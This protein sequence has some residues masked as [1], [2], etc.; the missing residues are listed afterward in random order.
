[1][2]SGFFGGVALASGTDTIEAERVVSQLEALGVGDFVLQ[3]LD[4]LVAEFLDTAALDADDM[5]VVIAAVQ[6]ENRITAFEVMT[7]HQAG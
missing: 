6:F 3:S 2:G 4:G 1:V 5:I 7:Y